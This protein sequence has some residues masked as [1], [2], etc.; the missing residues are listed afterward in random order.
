M[1]KP[2]FSEGSSLEIAALKRLILSS[3]DAAEINMA[4]VKLIALKPTISWE[5]L[6]RNVCV[7]IFITFAD[8]VFVIFFINLFDFFFYFF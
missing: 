2:K 7:N 4:L 5:K 1:I 3:Y 6:N 8:L